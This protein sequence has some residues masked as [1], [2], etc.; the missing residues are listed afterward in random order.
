[1][2]SK[3]ISVGVERDQSNHIEKPIYTY[4]IEPKPSASDRSAM[5]HGTTDLEFSK[6]KV[7]QLKGR[8]FTERNTTGE[9]SFKFRNQKSDNLL[10]NEEKK[11]PMDQSGQIVK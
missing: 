8:Y 2:T 11:H 6:S 7:W 5:H 9:M 3:S 10:G 4:R 1:M